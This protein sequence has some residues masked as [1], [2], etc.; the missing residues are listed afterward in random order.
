MSDIQPSL[1]RVSPLLRGVAIDYKNRAD[2]FVASIIM[3]EFGVPEKTGIYYK[4]DK[5][6]LR[7]EDTNRAVGE[8]SNEATFGLSQV[9]FGPIQDHALKHFTD[10]DTAKIMGG[11]DKA[12]L[13]ATANLTQLM[14]INRESN[15]ATQLSN[16]SVLTQNTTLSGTSQWSDYTS[17]VSDPV[18]VIQDGKDAIQQNAFVQPNVLMFSYL[19]Y[20]SVINHPSIVGR[21]NGL[22]Y[23]AG[24][25]VLATIFGVAKVVVARAA[26]NTAKQGAS[27]STSYLWGKHTW[28]FYV[29]P[30]AATAYNELTFGH[31]LNVQSDGVGITAKE[32]RDEDREGDYVRIAMPFEHK[33]MAV[34][35]AYLIK[36]SVA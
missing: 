11:M 1:A 8:A 35:A 5:S 24:L 10:D 36:D 34:E 27:D 9:S 4:Y 21:L 15:L 12:K 2:A 28:L 26:Y 30:S 6:A 14:L 18:G 33:I 20:A 29:N 25:D 19:A 22:T 31:T 7:L 16:T 32:W 17:G 23:A 13:V 3:P